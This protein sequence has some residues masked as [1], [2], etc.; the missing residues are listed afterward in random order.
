MAGSPDD[1]TQPC[2]GQAPTRNRWKDLALAWSLATLCLANVW[3]PLLYSGN[4]GYF[5]KLPINWPTILAFLT[6][7]AG[8]T[9]GIWLLCRFLGA[10]RSPRWRFVAHVG[11]MIAMLPL[12]D[13]LRAELLLIKDSTLLKPAVA[14]PV[15][16]GIVAMLWFRR[17]V[18]GALQGLLLI[19]TPL[20]MLVLIRTAL[21]CVSLSDAPAQQAA[22]PE[23][24]PLTDPRPGP[25]VLWLIFDEMDYR[26][27]FE[28]PLPG[29][30]MPALHALTREAIQLTNATP[31]G[32]ATLVSI[33]ALTIG[34]ALEKTKVASAS[35]L[36]LMEPDSK[37]PLLW[38]RQESVFGAARRLGFRTAV[39]GWYH[40]YSRIF[41]G[42]LDYCFWEPM[43]FSQHLRAEDYWTAL[44][45]QA[46]S[47]G[48]TVYVRHKFGQM[49][50]TVMDQASRI[51]TNSSFGLTMLHVPPPHLP[52]V[53]NAATGKMRFIPVRRTVGYPNN[54]MWAD[55]F[56][57]QVCD[58]LRASGE[59]EDIW[60]IVTSDHSW[61]DSK[62]VDGVRDKRVPFLVKAPG[63]NAPRV[64]GTQFSTLK[65]SELVLQVLRG[66]IQTQAE[67]LKWIM[68][69]DQDAD[70]ESQ[71]E[72]HDHSCTE[73]EESTEKTL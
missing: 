71:H 31:P 42:D 70:C 60:L 64:C 69:S 34:R 21:L 46:A 22:L 18:A 15:L 54:L 61:R 68:C 52:G 36:L 17:Q 73:T 41:A 20:A 16:A 67:A 48:R 44:F 62:V 51:A 56:L 9:L 6:N 35:E 59:W 37:E 38:T 43:A 29:L 49:C 23:P 53:Y 8:L 12:V 14:G 1:E 45:A 11:L 32:D 27:I 72:P 19:M 57:G 28:K 50:E 4:R 7:L 55:R 65:T 40:P 13:F 58:S 3:F 5:S 24:V 2:S 47:L 30:S 25:R 10:R 66:Q 33:P 63:E 39:V 26:L